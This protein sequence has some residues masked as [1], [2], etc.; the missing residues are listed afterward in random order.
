M[1]YTPRGARA[2]SA[3]LLSPDSQAPRRP[4]LHPPA[5]TPGIVLLPSN[6]KPG[7]F[8]FTIPPELLSRGP[9]IGA[10][11]LQVGTESAAVGSQ[12]TSAGFVFHGKPHG[13]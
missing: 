6:A 12:I 7:H 8:T 1:H 3:Q 13:P 4:A 10:P 9:P 2:T 11:A 5:S